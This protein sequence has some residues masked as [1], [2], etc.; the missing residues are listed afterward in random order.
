M[1]K[2][3]TDN[4]KSRPRRQKIACSVVSENGTGTFFLAQ[5]INRSEYVPRDFHAAASWCEQVDW[6]WALG[7]NATLT[8]D[9]RQD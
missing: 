4:S 6:L 2:M 9:D 5:R 3:G 7:Q 8:A 1:Y